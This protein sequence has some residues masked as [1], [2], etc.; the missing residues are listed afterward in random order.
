MMKMGPTQKR[1]KSRWGWLGR[2]LAWGRSQ[3][4][5]LLGLV[6][7]LVVFS[8][9]S[10]PF[11]QLDNLMLILLQASFI[12]IVAAGQTLVVLTGGIDLSVG[13][14]IGLTG[15]VAA[16]LMK[17]GLGSVG[18]LPSYAAIAIALALGTAI[19]WLHGLVIAKRNMPPFIVTL[20]SLSVLRGIALVITN[21][22]SINALPDNFKWISDADLGILPMPSL[23]M[24]GTFAV[25]AYVLRNTKFG[26]YTYAIG[27]NEASARLSGVPVD[28]YKI[29][30]YMLSGFLAAVAGIVLIA[31]LDSGAYTYGEGYELSSVAAVIIG[32]TSLRGG[33][34][35]V[36]G[37]L[38]GVL[39]MATVSNGMV[40]LDI[41]PL[42]YD[43]ISGSIILLAVLI[44]VERRRAHKAAPR[45]QIQPLSERFYL[46]EITAKVAQLIK[47]RFGSPYCRIYMIDPT[48]D[49]LVE[50]RVGAHMTAKVG[51]IASQVRVSGSSAILDNLTSRSD[52]GL[53]LLD[54][55][56][57]SAAVIPLALNR[58][59]IGVIEVQ[60]LS[61][62]SF[63]P[64]TV[65]QMMQLSEEIAPPLR[66]A[67]LLECGWLARQ[68]RIALHNLWDDV[69]LGRCS[70]AE[71]AFPASLDR[72]AESSPATRGTQLREL[73]LKT[74][75][76]LKSDHSQEDSRTARR[77][78]ILRLTYVESHTV[79]E[80]I[81]ELNVSRRQYFY[82]QKVALDALAHLL[83]ARQATQ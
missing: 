4:S 68:T 24:L 71:W 6:L 10:P 3:T 65:K 8:V 51:S 70:L 22:S 14:L 31:R 32:G 15:V 46:S 54:P 27:G 72:S 41:S 61:P 34:G 59:A 38:V 80:V 23:I 50:C 40:M 12:G 79:N 81:K 52:S 7:V 29:Y 60:S 13:S 75:E 44:D 73:L 28:P 78:E 47:G 49:D 58:Q 57:Q 64:E 11:R 42:W 37:S 36:W 16:L 26:R 35:G 83:I 82:D 62:H 67:W 1:G 19:G 76:S 9:L 56:V 77:H 63:T 55:G 25:L 21:A 74:I 69:Q 66:D 5:V 33:I 53:S 20:G 43:I 18:P 45:V 17:Q 48:S 39:I 30:V 2:W